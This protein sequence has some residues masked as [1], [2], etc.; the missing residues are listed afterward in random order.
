[1]QNRFG[2]SAL[3]L[4]GM[5]IVLVVG[6]EDV[7]SADPGLDP[8]LLLAELSPQEKAGQMLI[9]YNTDSE[10]LQEY[11]LGGV[12][13][14]RNMIR[15][16]QEL[17][18]ELMQ[19]QTAMRIP[20]L[21]CIDQEGGNVNRLRHIDQFSVT[22]SAQQM[23]QLLDASIET[24]A[25][26]TTQFLSKVGINLNFAPCLDPMFDAKGDST[27]MAHRQRSFGPEPEA[28][29]HKAGA[30]L[31]GIHA[32]DGLSILKHFPG[33]DAT[34][35]SDLKITQS[36]A[37]INTIRRYIIP[38]KNLI[39][40]SNGVMMSNVVYTSLDSLPAV[41]S[42]TV[43]GLAR[44]LVGDKL[45]LTD[46]LWAVSLREVVTPIGGNFKADIPDEN[47]TH[48]VQMALIAGNDLLLITYPKK[49]P[50]MIAA[51]VELMQR[52]DSARQ[53]VDDAVLRILKFKQKL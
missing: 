14:F 25:F 15:S 28:I 3:L 5:T 31:D 27:F 21:V 35:N 10:F 19:K 20:L 42:P 47:F 9:V 8:S 51:I 13:L 46:D 26:Q 44:E 53:Q 39:G 11:S 50:V 29:T 33:Y 12:I 16:E 17:T 24:I 36:A 48:L 18:K 37:D 52:S 49:I 1:M 32:S 38:F 34:T 7:L 30:F 43:V 6:P 41:L 4:A 22:Y 2:I 45:I 40:K 23:G